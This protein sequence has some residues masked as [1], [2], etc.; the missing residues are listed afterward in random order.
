MI[1]VDETN[2]KETMDILRG[3]KKLPHIFIELKDWLK[4]TYNITVYNFVVKERIVNKAK[5]IYELHLLLSSA[6]D[7]NSI[8][9]D[10]QSYKDKQTEIAKK[11]RLL[12]EK[13][14]LCNNGIS[15]DIWIEFIDFEVEMRNEFYIRIFQKI[16]DSLTDK[17]NKYSVWKI[18]PGLSFGSVIVFY[19][20]DEDINNNSKDGINEQIKNDF[21]LASKEYDE[22]DVTRNDEFSVKYDSK[23]SFEKNYG[24]NWRAY[25]DA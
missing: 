19:Y 16:A 3:N 7:Y 6:K 8:Y 18:C 13:Y 25:F 4:C 17:Y 21:Y 20:N 14:S 9:V 2:Y 15:K 12:I 11:L 23:D 5:Q 24:G 1:N 10:Y 22:F